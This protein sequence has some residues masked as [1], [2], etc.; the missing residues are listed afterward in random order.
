MTV[1][2]PADF[3]NLFPATGGALYGRAVHGIAGGVPEAG[4]AECS[5][6]AVSGGGER[7]S[8][9]GR[10]DGSAVGTPGG[11]EPVAGPDFSVTPPTGG[12]VWWYVD[13]LSD[14]GAF[15]ITLIA[16]L[17][18]V[19]SPYYAWMR[20]R[21]GGDPM[22]HCALNVALYG[23]GKRWAMTERGARSV[24]RGL[25]F[26]AIGPSALSWDGAG[27]T[28]R[29]EEIAMPLPR[30]IRGTVRLYP[31]AVSTRRLLL[32]TAG[33]HR[34]QPI[35]PCARVEVALDQPGI[36]WSGPA[37]FDTNEGDRPLEADFVRWD[38][39]RAQLPG[40]T[41]VLYE[42][43]RRDGPLTLA[44]RY[45]NT[46]GVTDYAPPPAV[47]LPATLWRVPRVIRAKAPRV[48]DTLEDTPFYARS[49]IAA[50]MLGQPVVA[51]HESLALDR[52]A[53]PWVQAML[54]FR[55]PRAVR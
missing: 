17:G 27:L 48:V 3:E 12:Y 51:V 10:A 52:F 13:A 26:L 19:F 39:S 21:G 29:I 23:K 11:G 31:S 55:M 22:Q 37:Y 53:A 5:S 47:S 25:D 18:S 4:F 43:G 8:G 36:S 33:R 14:D 30:R 35:A 38:W 32:D 45:E 28:V 24:Q 1:T 9:S 46:G 40:G 41:G 7:A 16:F 20:R 15:G 49:V 2:A 44:M 34:W 50:E 6:A 54:P 42:V